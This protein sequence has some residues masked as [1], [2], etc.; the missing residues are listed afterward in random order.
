LTQQRKIGKGL[1]IMAKELVQL[2]DQ[3][4]AMTGSGIYLQALYNAAAEVGYK[5][6]VI[7][8]ALA[9]SPYQDL[10]GI[11]R[12]DFY[13][14]LFNSDKLPYAPFG[15]SDNMPYPSSQYRNM[16]KKQKDSFLDAYLAELEKV[17]EGF[18]DPII[19]THHLWLVAAEVSKKYQ[20]LKVMAVCHGTGI[21]QLRQNPGFAAEVKEGLS[22]LKQVFALND[23]QKELIVN[24]FS[25]EPAQIKVTGL[26]YNSQYFS[27][28]TEQEIIEK[29]SKDKP[30]LIYVGKLSYSK[31]VISLIKALEMIDCR[32]L[33]VTLIGSGQGEEAQEIK[34]RASDL[35]YQVEFTGQISQAEVAKRLRLADLLCLP[36]FYEGF[37]L[38][39]LEALA[40]GLRIVSSDLPGVRDK[41]PGYI[42]ETG[43]INFIELPELKDVDKPV[44]SDLPGYE[45]RLAKAVSEQLE[46]VDELDFLREPEYKKAVQSLNWKSV[47]AEIEAEF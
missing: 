26:G 31:G 47:F 28:P 33:K 42:K 11:A 14:V 32:N 16:S 17:L 38:V 37:A 5:Q 18:E 1:I 6:A 25:I 29:R 4:P 30:E 21:R 41:I 27:L 35:K 46:K 20:D 45:R 44:E 34:A 39:I 24:H 7:G 8:A 9:D 3:R 2:L 15:M 10:E 22:Y 36:S 43:T 13:P 12:K 23:V 40:S 19:L